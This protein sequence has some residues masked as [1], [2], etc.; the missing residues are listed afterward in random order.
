M[1]SILVIGDLIII[2]NCMDTN[3]NKKGRC[4]CKKKCKGPCKARLGNQKEDVKEEIKK[5]ST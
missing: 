5:S 2:N 3:T 4:V 1:G